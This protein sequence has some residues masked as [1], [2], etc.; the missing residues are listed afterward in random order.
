MGYQRPTFQD[1]YENYIGGK[2]VAPVDGKYFEDT[3][4]IDNALVTRIPR[5]T[6][7]DI[8]L[9]V[10]AA[11]QAAPAWGK[12]SAAERSMV[13]F[14]I[15]DCMEA[16]IERLAVVE[17]CDNGKGI[18]E[19][20]GADLPIA[21][22]QFRYFAGCIRTEAGSV[23]NIDDD[24]VSME[25]HE[26]YGVVGA[27]IPWNFPL[28]MAAWKIAPAIAAGNCI[29]VKPAEQTPVSVLILMEVLGDILPPGVVNIVNGFGPEAGKPLATH[30]DVK[31]MAFTGETTTGRLIMQYAAENLI[32]VSLE[33]GGKSPNI[34]MESVMDADDEFFDKAIEG[35]VLFALNQG[36]VCTAP[37][38]ALIQESIYEKFMARCLERIAAIKM[39]DPYE[40]STMMGA[41]ASNDQF[42]KIMSYIDI[43]KQEGAEVLCGGAAHKNDQYPN[44]FYVQ[45]TVFKGHNKMRVFQEEIFGPVLAV[46]TFKDEDEALAIA[47]DTL[48][49][50]GSAIWS[51]DMHQVQKFTRGLQAGRVWVNCYHV[52]PAG[53]SFGGYKN[54]GFGRENHHM[55]LEHYRQTKNV[56]ISY[57]KNKLG[58]F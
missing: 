57:N 15:A 2:W 14:K 19:T 16:N 30:P 24:T 32:P 39:G 26:P 46:T 25:V 34:F 23:T 49:G 7:K 8:D 22:D 47:N 45:P 20:L 9:A 52:Y 33:L 41:Q 29:V 54:S 21:I 50:L 55:M 27:I 28:L 40:L 18:R 56:L 6:S 10:E 51:R 44:G 36:Q 13:L 53:A 48:Y 5:S 31:K 1:K 42:E 37:S 43:G 12:T 4:P 58:F 17:T 35:L 38:R 11:W 3:S